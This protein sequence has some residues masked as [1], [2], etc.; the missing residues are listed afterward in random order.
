MNEKVLSVEDIDKSFGGVHALNGV[1]MDIYAGEIHCLAGENGSGK[2]TL[3]KIISGFYKPDSGKIIVNGNTYSEMNSSESISQGVQVIYQDF[4]LFPNLS[5][6]ENLSINSEVAR[7]SKII[8][9]NRMRETAKQAVNKIGLKID[10]KKKV[11]DLSVADRQMIAI[12]RALVHDA[13]VIIMDEATSS[14]TRNEVNALFKVIHQLKEQGVAIVFVSHKMDEVFEISDRITIFRNGQNVISCQA[15]EMDEN[16]FSFYM[17]GREIRSKQDKPLVG[18]S[19]QTVLEAKNLSVE[20][21]FE[22]VSFQLHKGEILG[23]A[24]QLGSG[25]TELAMT[26]FGMA[27]IKSG[28]I[29]LNGESVNISSSIKAKQLKIAYVPEDRVTEGLF[30]EHTLTENTIVT[31][32]E[33]FAHR[34]G[35]FNKKAAEKET[36]Q[37]MEALSVVPNDQNYLAQKLSGGN[38]QKIVL[39]KWLSCKPVVLILNGPTVGVDIG[40]KQDIYDLLNQYASQGMSI[41]IASD[42]VVEIKKLC[43][44]VI[45]MKDGRINATLVGEEVTETALTEASI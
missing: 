5:V 26:L 38:Q 29:K 33:N 42:D 20:S 2:S 31:H 4:S 24:G 39:A 7:R 28:E 9:Y 43:N 10:M 32:L 18:D 1:S 15:S 44:R 13:K 30:L 3:I 16:K 40:A 12:A 37:W 34:F 45:I 22:D 25:R 27:T 21:A 41:I 6:M 11:A 19:S 8:S 36:E 35:I 17:T 14:L 23:I